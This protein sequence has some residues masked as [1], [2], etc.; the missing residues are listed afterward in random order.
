MLADRK[1]SDR[2][3]FDQ[4]HLDRYTGGDE[5]LTDPK[6]NELNLNFWV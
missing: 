2:P 5:A 6:L 1:F 4:A 3:L